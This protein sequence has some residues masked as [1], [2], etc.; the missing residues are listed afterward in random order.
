MSAGRRVQGVH[1]GQK[2]P[3]VGPGRGLSPSLPSPPRLLCPGVP[4]GEGTIPS[5]KPTPNSLRLDFSPSL[6]LFQLA[7]PS[8]THPGRTPASERKCTL[9]QGRGVGRGRSMATVLAP[10]QGQLAGCSCSSLARPSLSFLD[11]ETGMLLA[12]ASGSSHRCSLARC[13]HLEAAREGGCC[14]VLPTGSSGP[15]PGRLLELPTSGLRGSQQ[16]V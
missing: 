12:S 5:A 11:C 14:G 16:G 3:G 1:L 4:Q 2:E 15:R 7:L 6:I 9:Q 10:G 8:G 13:W